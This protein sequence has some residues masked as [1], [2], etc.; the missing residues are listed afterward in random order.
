MTEKK[1]ITRRRAVIAGLA[2]LGG[3]ALWRR[4]ETL[5]PTYGNLLRMGDSFTYAAHRV[6]LPGG[7]LA[8][9]YGFTEDDGSL[10]PLTDKGLMSVMDHSKIP[11]YW[12]GVNRFNE[13]DAV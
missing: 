1:L 8:R 5:P 12:R 4:P 7:A 13:S 6:L 9:E 11:D 3:L 2:G 10:P